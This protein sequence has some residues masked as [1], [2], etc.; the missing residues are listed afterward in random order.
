M[1]SHPDCGNVQVT[2][3]IAA[4]LVLLA[5]AFLAAGAGILGQA[6]AAC[7]TQPPA[8]T[9]AARIPAAYLAD[10][11]NAGTRYG[12]AWTVL[13]GIGEIESGQ[14]R[15][16][17]PG[18]HSGENAAG[19]AGP[20]QFGIGGVAGNTWGAPRSTLRPSTPAGTASTATTT[21]P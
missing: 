17:A 5:V 9:A 6:A 12:I 11:K 7:K 15:S 19:A 3:A 18:V 10:Y 16:D 14:G 1:R 8:S 2:A 21:G 20:M 13:A 4:A